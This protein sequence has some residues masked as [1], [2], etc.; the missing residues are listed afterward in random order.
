MSS[1]CRAAALRFL[2]IRPRSVQEL[3]AKLDGKG[4]ESQAVDETIAYLES[5]NL[6]D[7]R[8][9]T[10]GWIRYRLARPF[11]FRRITTELKAKGIAEDIISEAIAGF[12]DEYAESDIVLE[13]AL[14]RAQRLGN[15][16]P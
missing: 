1:Q 12:K 5:I 15:I 7:D 3:R 6:L 2:K 16:D 11:G 10:A 9:F 4:F 14:R 13:L 8:A